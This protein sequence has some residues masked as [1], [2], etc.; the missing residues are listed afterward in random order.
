MIGRGQISVS[1]AAGVTHC[2]IDDGLLLS[3]VKAFSSLGNSGKYPANYERD[4]HTWLRNLFGFQLEPYCVSFNLQ[5]PG[6]NSSV[7]LFLG[8]ICHQVWSK[9][10]APFPFR[11]WSS[12]GGGV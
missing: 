7:Y 4:L 6:F 11:K 1:A 10:K 8:D 2:A 5:V 9:E 12:E 3:A